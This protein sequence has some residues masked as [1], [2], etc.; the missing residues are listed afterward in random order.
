MLPSWRD[1]ALL[2][3][4]RAVPAPLAKHALFLMR[5]HPSLADSLGYHVR[6]IQYYE[7]LP[8]FQHI[9]AEAT[10]RPR[11]SAAIDFDL[12]GQQ[13]LA[14]RLAGT[15]RSEVAQPLDPHFDFAN[16]YFG[17]GDAAI[18]YA[19]IRDL[20][21]ARIVEIGAGMSSRIA[22]LA[23]AR[24]R[25]DGHAG[26]LECIEPFPGPR[27]TDRMPETVVIEKR[28]EDVPLEHFDSLSSNDILF[29]DSS[30]AVKFGGDVCREF[31]EI[32]PRLKPGV[33]IHVH[34]VFFPRDYPA[35]WLIEQRHAFT[36][37]YLLEA[38][39]AF[40]HAFSVLL[41]LHWLW[42]DHRELWR[43]WPAAV[44]AAAEQHPPSSFWMT[45]VA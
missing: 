27:L 33:W 4:M 37:Q 23:L 12:D 19:L 31:L 10:T 8:D 21:P 34:D 44:Y 6:P 25:E 26:R 13:R 30:H 20:R 29:I 28:V 40:N 24:N 38:F 17:G 36:E 1:R 22:A 2:A 32:L 35:A 5:T 43:E 9:A 14:R 45:R 16:D 11:V 42:S 39:L 7:P 41:C 15:W 3:A 18:Y